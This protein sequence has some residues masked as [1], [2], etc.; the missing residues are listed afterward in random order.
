[1]EIN[2]SYFQ[3]LKNQDIYYMLCIKDKLNM[4]VTY[5]MKFLKMGKMM[6]HS[7]SKNK[8]VGV[9]M[10]MLNNNRLQENEY[11]EV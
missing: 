3:T 11:F 5:W 9:A 2:D 10:L 8:E 4:K 7:N 1:M 6:Y